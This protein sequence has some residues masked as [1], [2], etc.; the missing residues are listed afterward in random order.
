MRYR[1]T[2]RGAHA[3]ALC[4]RPDHLIDDLETWINAVADYMAVHNIPL[5]ATW[6]RP[7]DLRADIASLAYGAICDAI[8]SGDIHR[9]HLANLGEYLLREHAAA[10][11]RVDLGLPAVASFRFTTEGE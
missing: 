5:P 11:V 6:G 8:D 4:F 3:L 10:R 2:K 9:E 1:Y 7:A